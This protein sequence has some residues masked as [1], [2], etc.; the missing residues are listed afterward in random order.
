MEVH[1]QHNT[2]LHLLLMCSAN[3][4]LTRQLNERVTQA[5]A[6][7]KAL[8]AEVIRLGQ[9]LGERVQSV[10]ASVIVQSEWMESNGPR[11]TSQPEGRESEEEGVNSVEETV[12]RVIANEVQGMEVRLVQALSERGQG[13]VA[14]SGGG[15]ER[16]QLALPE[17][18][19]RQAEVMR[20][21]EEKLDTAVTTITQ[22]Q[23]QSREDFKKLE[24]ALTESMERYD[25]KREEQE[26]LL[27]KETE[28]A[29]LQQVSTSQEN[30]E[31]VV[32]RDMVKE[33]GKRE[34]EVR[35]QMSAL[36]ERVEEGVR[37]VEGAVGT[38][39]QK[40]VAEFSDVKTSLQVVHERT[41]RLEEL[42]R[43]M[44]ERVGQER[45]VVVEELK[46]EVGEKVGEVKTL[47]DKE[48]AE[49][50]EKLKGLSRSVQE[51]V[52]A[53][54]HHRH[55][56]RHVSSHPLAHTDLHPKTDE[57][58]S[59]SKVPP[60]PQASLPVAGVSESPKPIREEDANRKPP[61][62]SAFLQSLPQDRSPLKVVPDSSSHPA[63]R[64]PCDFKI[65]QFSKLKEQNKEW[66]SPPFYSPRG[67]K[68]C[69]GLW[70]NGFRSGAGTHVSIEFYKMRDANTD[71]L[72]WNV[73]LPI[74]VRIYNYRTKKWEKEHVNGDTFIRS[75]VSGEFE[76]SGYAQSHKLVAHD[77][78]KDYLLDDNFRIQIYK[79]EVKH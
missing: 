40:V 35:K 46:R 11:D 1:V 69:L 23:T 6:E 37:T 39:E 59:I 68:M 64:P 70:P 21:V 4:D 57:L 8:K 20:A 75:K 18:V 25:K 36:G 41:E 3:L 19:E 50:E 56:V 60:L 13:S 52:N 24:T 22:I 74:H 42:Q 63:H 7:T 49:M 5:E 44:E 9:T 12:K 55:K 48:V 71:K 28:K 10:E 65:E 76:T 47:V 31:V 58:D 32:A 16:S 38:M 15:G 54:R 45:E 61:R 78:L 33:M 67:Y 66:R 17:M 34:E 77:E 14:A 26:K 2:Q 73:K 53:T 72:K 43:G 29:L 79:F 51:K 27:M 30:L 62:A